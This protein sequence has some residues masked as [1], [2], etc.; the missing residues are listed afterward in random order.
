MTDLDDP[1]V[2]TRF[3]PSNMIARI[4]QL[5]Q[6]CREAWHS[7][8]G[9]PLPSDYSRID[10]AV[11][12][13]MGGSAIGGDLVAALA[14]EGGPPVSVHR[15]YDLPLV[16]EGTLVI[17][18]SYS[19]NTEETLS[20]F[21]K[22]L[23]TPAKKLAITTGG[24]L[25]TLAEESGVPVFCFRY[26]SEPRTAL[27][28]IFFSLLGL[29]RKLGLVPIE[30]Q[31]IDE[32]ITILEE[33]ST[34]LARRVPMEANPAKQLAIRLS[35]RL[36]LV[37]GAGILSKVAL[38]WKT[39]LNENSKASAFSECLPELDHNAVVGYRFP[40]WLGEKVFVVMLRSP[41]LHPRTLIR[42]EVTAEILADAGIAH[43]VVE[44]E[45]KSPLSQMM[46]AVLWGD[47][48]SYYLAMLNN[49]DPSPVA[50]I[51]HLKERLGKIE[52]ER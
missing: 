10:R 44:A 27:G 19:G 21:A 41:S 39:Q 32:T 36:V 31:D 38:R 52:V 46:S 43:E 40:S 48:V 47:Y 34:R 37:Y 3:D 18:S 30:S 49:V 4:G 35:E 2:Y 13:G 6:Q 50:V 16:D 24:R 22:A 12:L 7:A 1:E 15:D 26:L 45:G 5:P 25:K 8:M 51:D 33:L 20:S 9:F 42:Y 14:L 28:Y 17:A 29:F 11:I 23:Q